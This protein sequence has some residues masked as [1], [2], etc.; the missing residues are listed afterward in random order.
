M[1][2]AVATIVLGASVA[3]VSAGG[4]ANGGPIGGPTGDGSAA[5]I[6]A[7][8]VGGLA[9]SGAIDGDDYQSVR[10]GDGSDAGAEGDQTGGDSGNVVPDANTPAVQGPFLEDGTLLKPIAVDTAIEDGS[11]LLR[12]YKVTRA[13]RWSGSPPSSTSR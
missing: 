7:A 3:S 1:A 9:R 10:A 12:T 2:V 6:P 11:G 4:P 13:T 5:R 8:A